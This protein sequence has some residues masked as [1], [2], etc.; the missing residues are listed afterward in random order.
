MLRLR[1]ERLKLNLSK[2]ANWTGQLDA[3]GYII[4]SNTIMPNFDTT[5]NDYRKLFKIHDVPVTETLYDSARHLV[6]YQQRDYLDNITEDENVS[7][8]FFQGMLRQKGNIESINKLLRTTKL[9]NND[10]TVF[11][12]YAFKI[13]EFGATTVNTQNEIQLRSNDVRIQNPLIEF[14]YEDNNID[15]FNR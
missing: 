4:R 6:G 7:F 11:E 9:N 13:G 14:T 2:T 10:M 5:A 8:E 15:V 12:E 1:Q 3:P